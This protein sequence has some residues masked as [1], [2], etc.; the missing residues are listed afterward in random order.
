MKLADNGFKD[1]KRFGH[2]SEMCFWIQPAH[3]RSG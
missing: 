1:G 3:W 2:L